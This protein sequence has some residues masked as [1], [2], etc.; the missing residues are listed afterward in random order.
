MVYYITYALTGKNVGQ[1]GLSEHVD[2]KPI[3]LNAK[4]IDQKKNEGISPTTTTNFV[5]K[6][7]EDRNRTKSALSKNGSVQKSGGVS[8]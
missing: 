1:Y 2:S 6:I 3:I 5:K 8:R 4:Q 7:E